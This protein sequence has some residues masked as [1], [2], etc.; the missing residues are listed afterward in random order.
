MAE[1]EYDAALRYLREMI[2]LTSRTEDAQE[3]IR[4]FFE[5]RKPVWTRPLADE[6]RELRPRGARAG[7]PSW[8]RKASSDVARGPRLAA[9]PR[10][11]RAA[12]APA[13]RRSGGRRPG[14]AP[15]APARRLPG[16][17]E[18]RA[19][20]RARSATARAAGSARA[21]PRSSSATA[22]RDAELMFIGEG[23]GEQED[24]QRAPL[25][26]PRRRAA[27]A[28]DREAASGSPRSDVYICNIVKCRP[29]GNRTP[30]ADEVATCRP[31]LDGQID[32]VRAA[33]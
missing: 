14:L 9:R 11:A 23:P 32:A 2:V 30:L 20:A 7:W 12:A 6:A 19:G 24:L 33:R 16:A 29:P 21:A 3:G 18:P 26:R 27:D 1:M 10:R 13:A 5:K 25:R 28:D 15:R 17:P 8:P 4:A 31:F 22:T